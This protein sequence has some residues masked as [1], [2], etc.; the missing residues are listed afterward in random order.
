MRALG[1]VLA[2]SV[3]AFLAGCQS[4]GG[5]ASLGDIGSSFEGSLGR[6]T[7]GSNRR[8]DVYGGA[9]APSM[10]TFGARGYAR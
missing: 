7:Y 2:L 6:D 5:D 10:P 4:S 1:L 9:T 3:S 8:M